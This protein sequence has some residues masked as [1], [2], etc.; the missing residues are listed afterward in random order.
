MEFWK[1]NQ[2]ESTRKYGR[3]KVWRLRCWWNRRYRA[4]VSIPRFAQKLVIYP[5]FRFLAKEDPLPYEPSNEKFVSRL[6]KVFVHEGEKEF[7]DS[8]HTGLPMDDQISDKHVPIVFTEMFFPLSQTDRVIKLLHEFF[9]PSNEEDAKGMRRTGA[10]AFE[11]YPGHE[12]PFWLSPCFKQPS[13]RLDVFWFNARAVNDRL[14]RDTFFEQFWTLLRENRIDF[15]L[16]WGKYMPKQDSDETRTAE[17]SYLAA[18]YPEQTWKAFKK[19]RQEVDGDGIFLSKYWKD[20]LGIDA[21]FPYYAPP[22]PLED[23]RERRW[24]RR[25]WEDTLLPLFARIEKLGRRAWI[26]VLVG[27][28]HAVFQ[29]E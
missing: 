16:H 10:F 25:T 6:L 9:N 20:R 13:V 22:Q 23:M 26:R 2:V 19:L 18:Q 14:T 7:H 17:A 21:P 12:S 3:R 27:G 24:M 1:A 28:I 4:F 15:R 29:A 5:F 8:W 11:I